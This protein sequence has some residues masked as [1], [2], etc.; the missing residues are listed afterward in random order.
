MLP[1]K[2]S[3]NILEQ[4]GKKDP[5]LPRDQEICPNFPEIIGTAPSQELE[6]EIRSQTSKRH[7][8]PKS[9]PG[10]RMATCGLS[11]EERKGVLPG[12]TARVKA[13]PVSASIPP[14]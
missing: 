13:T 1:A 2:A 11:P 6:G 14:K 3:Q 10:Q 4:P 5:E 8:S 9:C 7:L 12:H